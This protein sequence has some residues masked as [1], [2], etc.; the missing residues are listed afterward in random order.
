LQ[1]GRL[2]VGV[3]PLGGKQVSFVGQH[4]RC[5]VSRPIRRG[6]NHRLNLFSYR[7]LLQIPA[8]WAYSLSEGPAALPTA[9]RS[10]PSCCR[11]ALKPGS[12]GPPAARSP[13]L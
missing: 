9:G 1:Q 4:S 13:A 5:C 11:S 8:N 2:E 3:P 7:L 10:L 6:S 12:R